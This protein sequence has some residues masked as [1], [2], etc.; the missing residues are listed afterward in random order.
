MHEM[1]IA[2]SVLQAVHNEMR[3]YPESYPSKVCVRIG[4]MAAV[5]QDSLRFCFEAI[6]RETEFERLRL[7]IEIC[8][9]KYQCRRCASDFTVRDYDVRCPHC[10][11]VETQCISGDELEL[12]YLEVEE[13]GTSA[14]GTEST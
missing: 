8:P 5:D 11:S 13:Y 1:G 4:E 10:A 6:T 12:A 3:R 9:L 14:V 7:E 2:N